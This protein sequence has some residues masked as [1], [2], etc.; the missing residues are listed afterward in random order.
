LVTEDYTRF[1]F[2]AEK[3]LSSSEIRQ[4]EDTINTIIKKS[5]LVTVQELPYEEAVE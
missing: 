1:D 3:A 4:I 2:A 5:L